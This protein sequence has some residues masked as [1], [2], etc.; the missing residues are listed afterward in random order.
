VT[1]VVA[2]FVDRHTHART[3][4]HT[5][6]HTH[7]HTHTHTH[8]QRDTCVERPNCI[9][10]RGTTAAKTRGWCRLSPCCRHRGPRCGRI[11]RRAKQRRLCSSW[12]ECSSRHLCRF[13]RCNAT[14]KRAS[15]ACVGAC[16]RVLLWS[17]VRWACGRRRWEV[18]VARAHHP[19]HCHLH[20]QRCVASPLHIFMQ[21]RQ[22]VQSLRQAL[23]T[24][25]WRSIQQLED[26]IE[27]GVAAYGCGQLC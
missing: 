5:Y 13:S 7:S 12:R 26:D 18:A 3:R 16:Q 4:T 19:L 23:D 27:R 11:H 17:R 15:G 25:A 9:H 10:E 2:L 22:P 21:V 8:T 1:T 24:H 14:V 6:T 20:S